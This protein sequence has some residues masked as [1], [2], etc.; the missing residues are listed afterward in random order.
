MKSMPPTNHSILYTITDFARLPLDLREPAFE[1]MTGYSSVEVHGQNCR[2]LQRP[3]TQQTG[4]KVMREAIRDCRA[5][6]TEYS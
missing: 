5:P 6:M 3:D 2:S 4:F 1:R